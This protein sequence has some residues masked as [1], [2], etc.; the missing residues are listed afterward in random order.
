MQKT[1][2]FLMF[3]GVQFGKAEE[4][5]QLYISLFKN[6]EIKSIA[7]IPEEET[8]G[9]TGVVRLALFTIDGV[10][11][12]AIDSPMEHDFNFTP[13]MSLFVTCE[14]E[15][16]I[17]MLFNRLSSEGTVMMPLDN[18][19]FSKKFGWISDKFGVSWQF[20]LEE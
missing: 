16:E 4:A 15:T 10:E 14:T 19:G 6:S 8:G 20:N 18:Y 2:T 1:S 5:M 11:Y 7:Y 17:E 9:K 3:S 12:R 13:S